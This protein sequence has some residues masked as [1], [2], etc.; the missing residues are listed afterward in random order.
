MRKR[1]IKS[2]EDVITFGKYKGKTVEEVYKKDPK[3]LYW[4]VNNTFRFDLPKD[5]LHQLHSKIF[6]TSF[7]STLPFGL[8]EG[9]KLS[10]VYYSNARYL[11]Y[12]IRH[13][14]LFDLPTDICDKIFE[15]AGMEIERPA[16]LMHVKRDN[17]PFHDFLGYYI[18]FDEK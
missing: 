17:V 16:H 11:A 1:K 12:M 7:D 6:I 9:Q 5:F 4:A 15:K 8:Y 13:C 2:I 10:T 18:D 3:Y 14:E